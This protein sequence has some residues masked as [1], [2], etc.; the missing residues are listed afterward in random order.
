VIV[1]KDSDVVRLVHYTTQEYLDSIQALLFPD[2]QTEIT[3]TLLTLLAFDGFPDSSWTDWETD[4]PPL[5]Q[6]S[7]Y[8]LVHAAG[9]PEGELRK[10]LLEFLHSASQW[11]QTME[12]TWNSPPWNYPDW[13]SQPSAL[14]IAAAANLVETVQFLLEGP[15]SLQQLENPEIIV[16][17]YNGHLQMVE[18]LV[19]KG[20]DMDATGGSYGSA[21]QAAAFKGHAENLK[22]VTLLLEKGAD[23]DVQGGS[24]TIPRMSDSNDTCRWEVRDSTASS[25]TPGK[26]GNSHTASQEGSGPEYPRCEHCNRENV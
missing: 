26:S 15:T 17:S 8:C 9:R 11:K 19:E 18:L 21:L 2:A 13:P 16:A 1:D 24:C 23:P 20:A 22:V 10:S 7:Q 25:V 6:Y 14:W 3:C 5:I 12:W 4:L